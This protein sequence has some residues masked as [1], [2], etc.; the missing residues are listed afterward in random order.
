MVSLRNSL[1]SGVSY[2]T[3]GNPWFPSVTS[4]PLGDLAIAPVS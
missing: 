1:R 2:D 3:E 4:F